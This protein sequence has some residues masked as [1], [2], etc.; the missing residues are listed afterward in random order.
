MTISRKLYK[1]T[2]IFER[3]LLQLH[4][5]FATTGEKFRIEIFNERDEK[6]YICELFGQIEIEELPNGEFRIG[7]RKIKE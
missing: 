7:G 4:R 2:E 3:V 6:I 1:R 5:H